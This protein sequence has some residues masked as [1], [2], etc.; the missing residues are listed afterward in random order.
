MGLRTIIAGRGVQGIKR[1]Q[2]CGND[3]VAFVDPNS[4]LAKFDDIADVPLDDYDVV[5][6]CIPDQPK[7]R[8]VE[9]CLKNGK[10]VL[11]EKPLWMP[12]RSSF[13]QLQ[14]IADNSQAVCYTAYNHRFEPHFVRM[15]NLIES[16]AWR[17][18]P[19]SHVYGMAPRNLFVKVNGGTKGQEFCQILDRN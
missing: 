13:A 2:I 5:L 4:N 16:G 6:A 8:L 15:K 10:H 7:E 14:S 1:E 17:D 19:L 12:D 11:V 3:F 18:I 9:Y